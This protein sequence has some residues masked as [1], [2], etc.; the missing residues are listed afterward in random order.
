MAEAVELYLYTEECTVN[1]KAAIRV[2]GDVKLGSEFLHSTEQIVLEGV[3]AAS[4]IIKAHEEITV[5][6]ERWVQ[7]RPGFVAGWKERSK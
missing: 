2:V 7:R 1:G 5:K 6:L 3:A 4:D